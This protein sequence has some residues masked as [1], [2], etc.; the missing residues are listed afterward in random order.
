MNQ[1]WLTELHFLARAV[2][3][4]VAYGAGICQAASITISG[5]VIDT[6]G[7]AIAGASVVLRSSGTGVLTG[8]DGSFSLEKSAAGIS[9]PDYHADI[10][11]DG[12]FVIQGGKIRVNTTESATVLSV[13][14]YGMNGRL[15][16][17]KQHA[18]VSGENTFTLPVKGTNIQICRI[19]F[20]NHCVTV[21]HIPAINLATITAASQLYQGV[22]ANRAAIMQV[23]PDIIDV[24]KEGMLDYHTMVFGRDTSGIIVTMLRS[25]GTVTDADGNIYQSVRIGNQVWTTENLRTTKYNDNSP[26]PFITDNN[27]WSRC[28]TGAYC[29]Y[30]NNASN[31]AIY[32][33]LY[34]W[35]AIV[36]GK[37]APEGWR[38]SLASDWDTLK[39]AITTQ[40]VGYTVLNSA[41]IAGRTHWAPATG[42]SV[43]GN[44][45][46]ST[47]LYGFNA[48]PGGMRDIDGNFIFL[49]TNTTWWTATPDTAI[50]EGAQ[51]RRL[52]Y[53]YNF[54]WES[55]FYKRCGFSIR[56]VRDL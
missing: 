56:L 47:N 48:L 11:K 54:L 29:S 17:Q 10:A 24:V 2:L 32:G 19:T 30:K 38:I 50:A 36:T 52:I 35:Y 8:I 13:K 43:P 26:I 9:A 45:T 34:N 21:K 42:V 37:L 18:L 3:L 25:A 7:V 41:K 14:A 16:F 27:E 28:T 20:G 39:E 55:S 40:M 1:V 53:N 46:D 31:V 49:D 6:A 4:L 33:L 15:L 5:H 44:I 23:S 51:G 12:S 22:P